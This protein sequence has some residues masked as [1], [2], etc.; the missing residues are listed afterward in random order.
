MENILGNFYCLFQS[1]FG[2]SMADYLW[3]LNIQTSDYS[4]INQ[5]FQFGLVSLIS[6]I[7]IAIVYYFVIN[8][9][10]LS[11]TWIW[12]IIA[13]ILGLINFGWSAYETLWQFGNGD[14]D[15]AFG[16]TESN[17]YG[18]AFVNFIVTVIFF[19]LI[20]LIVKRFSSNGKHTPWKSIWP[21]H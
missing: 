10:S 11:K 18:F 5:F 8:A 7:V 20:S 16:I 21:K 6:A 19:V 1:L 13:I 4:E 9:A 15:E 17:C 12:L 3:G 2:N 14:I